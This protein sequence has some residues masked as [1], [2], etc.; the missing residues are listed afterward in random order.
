VTCCSCMYLTRCG[1]G[2]GGGGQAS[3]WQGASSA[4]IRGLRVIKPMKPAWVDD[5]AW[6]DRQQQ[7]ARYAAVTGTAVQPAC[8]RGAWSAGSSR[9]LSTRPTRPRGAP[10]TRTPA[11]SDTQ[12]WLR[13]Q[14]GECANGV[15]RWSYAAPSRTPRHEPSA[16]GQSRPFE[17][18]AGGKAVRRMTQNP[19]PEKRHPLG[20][21]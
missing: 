19:A 3:T 7:H 2:R 1:G 15:R 17:E 14:A 9:C 12:R 4:K 20:Q 11:V 21:S 8:A 10:P 5:G 6:R 13:A 16:C 18:R